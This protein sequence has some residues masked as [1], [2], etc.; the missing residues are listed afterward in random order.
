MGCLLGSDRGCLCCLLKIGW[1]WWWG[2]ILILNMRT[3]RGDSRV[4]TLCFLTIP[5]I[6]PS[7]LRQIF[8]HPAHACK[9]APAMLMAI[10]R[11]L[12]YF[13]VRRMLVAHPAP[14]GNDHKKSG[15]RQAARDDGS[16]SVRL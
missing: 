14:L 2:I 1:L 4:V 13:V 5:V 11:M 16:S 10:P 6:L 7:W 15:T 9:A 12:L 8:T 3:R